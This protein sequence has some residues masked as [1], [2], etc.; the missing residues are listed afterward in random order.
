M[1]LVWGG[2]GFVAVVSDPEEDEAGSAE[3]GPVA[4][5]EDEALAA[6]VVLGALDG[7]V[8]LV[9]IRRRPFVLVVP[10]PGLVVVLVAAAVSLHD[11]VDPSGGFPP[12]ELV[13]TQ[14][15]AES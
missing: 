4:E 11:A 9:L 15:A 6:L 14:V 7:P 5:A 8:A 1:G 10:G 12:A 2:L 3:A 13:V